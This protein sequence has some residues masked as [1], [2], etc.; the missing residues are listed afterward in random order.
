MKRIA[1][2]IMVLTALACQGPVA[3][4]ISEK[5]SPAARP[6]IDLAAPDRFET[7]SFALG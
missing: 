2:G 3:T 5:N 6:P 4:P 7:A 1:I